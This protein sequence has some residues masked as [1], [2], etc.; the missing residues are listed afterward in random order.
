MTAPSG[1]HLGPTHGSNQQA[2]MTA[3]Q[4]VVLRGEMVTQREISELRELVTRIRGLS[5]FQSRAL[6]NLLENYPFG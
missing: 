1:R 3:L 2:L 6:S 4:N 5:S